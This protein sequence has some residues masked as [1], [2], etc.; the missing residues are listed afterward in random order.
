MFKIRGTAGNINCVQIGIPAKIQPIQAWKL[1]YFRSVDYVVIPGVQFPGIF[2]IADACEI[3]DATATDVD[4]FN[5]KSFFYRDFPVIITIKAINQDP[6]EGFSN[7]PFFFWI[8]AGNG[9]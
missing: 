9:R 8:L 3:R 4:L 6:R 7:E 5:E 2:E 1:G